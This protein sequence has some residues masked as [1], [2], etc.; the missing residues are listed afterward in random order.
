MRHF[1]ETLSRAQRSMS[2]SDMMRRRPGTISNSEP[3]KAPDL[4]RTVS[5]CAAS[6]A[7][8][9]VIVMHAR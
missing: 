9:K 1:D 5:R 2:A 8:N 3:G 4:R 7:T 6:G